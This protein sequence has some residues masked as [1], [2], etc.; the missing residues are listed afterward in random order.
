MTI[1]NM[2]SHPRPAICAHCPMS[3]S[4]GFEPIKPEAFEAELTEVDEE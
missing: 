2:A 3:W 4:G 1:L